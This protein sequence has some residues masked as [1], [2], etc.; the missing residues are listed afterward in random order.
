MNLADQVI[1]ANKKPEYEVDEFGI[2]LMPNE[3]EYVAARIVTKNLFERKKNPDAPLLHN[4]RNTSEL[5]L[6]N[7][8]LSMDKKTIYELADIKR[9]IRDYEI[10]VIW[11]SVLTHTCALDENKIMISSH[12]YWD[13]EKGELCHTTERMV[14]I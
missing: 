14:A 8:Q 3:P 10:Q 12:M 13:I 2:R 1:E 4:R 9:Q 5:W 6:G 11:N 7:R